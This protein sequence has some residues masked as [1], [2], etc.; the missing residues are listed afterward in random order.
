MHIL[1][2]NADQPSALRSFVASQLWASPNGVMLVAS[3]Q[4]AETP[5]NH[6]VNA[7][8]SKLIGLGCL[9]FNETCRED[10]PTLP[11]V[12]DTAYLSN[13]ATDAEHQRQV[14]HEAATLMFECH[15]ADASCMCRLGVAMLLLEACQVVCK[16]AGLAGISLHVRQDDSAAKALY[17][18]AGFHV[19]QQD[20]WL[21]TMLRH[22]YRP[23]ELMLK[24]M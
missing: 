1:T 12:E 19:T 15:S 9:A 2:T 10:F 23:R 20:S 6:S 13:M 5:D 18:K 17:L 14:L 11:P 4:Q 7:T 3:C 22:S 21:W 16:Q 24:V 8:K